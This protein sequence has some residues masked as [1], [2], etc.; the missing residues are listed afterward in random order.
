MRGYFLTIVETTP[1]NT[2]GPQIV[3]KSVTYPTHPRVINT[4]DNLKQIE[5]FIMLTEVDIERIMAEKR[6]LTESVV[7]ENEYE[8]IDDIEALELPDDEDTP[9]SETNG[10]I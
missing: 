9:V 3:H 8:L 5:E 10:L 6:Q 1:K 4:H 7:D 2:P